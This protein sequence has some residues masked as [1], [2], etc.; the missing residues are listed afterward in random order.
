MVIFMVYDPDMLVIVMKYMKYKYADAFIKSGILKFGNASTWS[1][2][3]VT[4]GAG[5][6]D[7][8][9]GVYA[10]C[11]SNDYISKRLYLKKYDDS[12]LHQHGKL[13]Y[14][15]SRRIMDLPCYCLYGLAVNDFQQDKI[16]NKRILAVSPEF[17]HEFTDIPTDNYPKLIKD[18]NRPSLILILDP[19]K[20]YGRIAYALLAYGVKADDIIM[21]GVYYIDKTKPMIC[22]ESPLEL[23]WKSPIYKHQNEVRIIVN[24]KDAE[25]INKLNTETLCIGSLQDIA[26]H[27]DVYFEKGLTLT[28]DIDEMNKKHKVGLISR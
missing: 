17:F 23:L 24:T 2:M 11:P 16:S 22:T 21:N 27:F 10:V 5:R 9:E 25:V 13:V 3:D 26:I 6:G 1:N 18:E 12:Y 19:Q 8:L 20:F 15:R 7:K 4:N 14:F 28:L